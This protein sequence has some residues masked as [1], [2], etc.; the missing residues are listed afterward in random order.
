MHNQEYLCYFRSG[1]SAVAQ[2]LLAVQVLAASRTKRN[3]GNVP[4][5]IGLSRGVDLDGVTTVHRQECLFYLR[6]ALDHFQSAGPAH[7]RAL[8]G[9]FSMYW[10]ILA[11]SVSFL[12]Q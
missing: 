10:R 5:A 2:P 3:A 4:Y 12:T 8:T 11:S 7:N 1:K 6:A 9:L